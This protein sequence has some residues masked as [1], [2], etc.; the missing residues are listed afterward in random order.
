MEWTHVVSQHFEF[1]E[2]NRKKAIERWFEMN[3][4]VSNALI[5]GVF[6]QMIATMNYIPR[7][8]F[9]PLFFLK[10]KVLSSEKS[11][12][13]GFLLNI[14]CGWMETSLVRRPNKLTEWMNFETTRTNDVYNFLLQQYNESIVCLR[15][16]ISV[17]R[18]NQLFS[19]LMHSIHKR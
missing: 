13:I 9:I 8:F 14:Q 11:R 4:S 12:P 15:I 10:N 17:V 7:Y 3:C 19:R 18:C 5:S 2:R 16:I 6:N 1:R